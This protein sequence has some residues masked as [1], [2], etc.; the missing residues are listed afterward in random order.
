MKGNGLDKP[1]RPEAIHLFNVLVAR[2]A[3]RALGALSAA[4]AAFCACCVKSVGTPYHLYGLK[5]AAISISGAL[6]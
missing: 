4:S 6:H 3:L 1:L 5:V 2:G